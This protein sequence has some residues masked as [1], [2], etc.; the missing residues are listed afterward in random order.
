MAYSTSCV[1]R[2]SFLA[3]P[4]AALASL[5]ACFV[6][7]GEGEGGVDEDGGTE[8][9]I[10]QIPEVCEGF[11]LFRGFFTRHCWQRAGQNKS[12]ASQRQVG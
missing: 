11:D 9:P 3:L 12:F 5:S 1:H 6:G 8:F 7:I 4:V 2:I 10:P